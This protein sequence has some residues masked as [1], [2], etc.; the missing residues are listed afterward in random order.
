MH[1][2][3]SIETADTADHGSQE[4]F[5]PPMLV[6]VEDLPGPLSLH[7]LSGMGMVRPLDMHHAYYSRYAGTVPGRAHMVRRF[8]PSRTIACT[9]TASWIWIGGTFPST[10][11]VVSASHFRT[12]MFGRKIRVFNRQTPQEQYSMVEG[13]RVTTPLR[14]ICD[15]ALLAD[16]EWDMVD[17]PLLIGS[18]MQSYDLSVRDCLDIL[19]VNRFWQH[20]PR[21]RHFFS[22]LRPRSEPARAA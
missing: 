21:A 3:P 7:Q 16:D 19:R 15:V 18:I 17:A 12:T 6:R 13:M 22:T 2:K 8:I 9:L 5:H 11:D 10:I 20:A 4:S 1:I 14:T